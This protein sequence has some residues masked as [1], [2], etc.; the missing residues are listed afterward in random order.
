MEY[1]IKTAGGTINFKLIRRK[2]KHIRIHVTGEQ[3]VAVSAPHHC[4]VSTIQ[5]FVR[6]SE[7]F[8][9]GRLDVLEEQRRRHYPADYWDGDF[10]SIFGHR[11]LLKVQ[12]AKRASAIFE[13][14]TLTLYVPPGGNAKTQFARWMNGQAR[15]AFK[16]RL[17]AIASK[18][19]GA[20]DLTLSVK[21]M[22]TR[23]GSINPARRR[24]SLSVHL[25][26]CDI[27]LIDYVITHELCHLNCLGHSAKFYRALEQH[28]PNRRAMDKRLEAY[29]LVDF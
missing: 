20:D 11:V 3:Q 21:R 23:W 28:Y 15:K 24:L 1:S 27:D 8:I 12:L 16:Q 25:I 6:D 22:L 5:A 7:A 9:R 4:A 2:M 10:F 26:R 18:F 17:S 14:G 13:N 19:S 29:G